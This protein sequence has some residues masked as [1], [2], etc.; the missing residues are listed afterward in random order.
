MSRF[1]KNVV[2]L[3]AGMIATQIIA[4]V[5]SIVFYRKL[6]EDLFGLYTAIFVVFNTFGIF[7]FFDPGNVLIHQLAKVKEDDHLNR[8]A[9]EGLLFGFVS[10]LFHCLAIAIFGRLLTSLWMS[11]VR[12]EN[13]V[14]FS[15]LLPLANF[16][17]QWCLNVVQ[18]LEK[19][20]QASV[21]LMIQ[22]LAR[23]LGAFAGF[24]YVCPDFKV[25][26]L[27][28]ADYLLAMIIGV[29]SVQCIAAIIGLIVAKRYIRLGSLVKR[30]F[31][32]R[33]S[34]KFLSDSMILSVDKKVTD[35]F[36][37]LPRQIIGYAFS[38]NP[39]M[40]A[41]YD[42]LVKIFNMVSATVNP[43]ARALLPHLTR[44]SEKTNWL[45]VK[46]KSWRVI[47]SGFVLGSLMSIGG[48]LGARYLIFPH[49]YQI[50]GV[51]LDEMTRCVIFFLVLFP[52]LGF[53]VINSA[54]ALILDR[55]KL[56][57]KLKF[58]FMAVL[59]PVALFLIPEKGLVGAS[60]Y[61]LLYRG[62]LRGI[63]SL[64]LLKDLNKRT[65]NL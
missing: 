57:F 55:L 14:L 13:A 6:G 63:T 23:P 9:G 7:L 33:P 42:I 47:R 27:S 16:P 45:E 53:G 1:L 59:F 12:L 25:D 35:Q 17:L 48:Y 38:S 5:V 58:V 2:W 50:K 43:L 62:S 10:A 52:V 30:I 4:L 24:L 8:L 32:F 39:G 26:S 51:H 18:G 34:K 44:T 46:E 36:E 20:K 31:K 29:V 65:A 3:Q 49:F 60:F 11:D 54:L 28:G 21:L 22:N 41:H 56:L 64:I 61:A 15:S 40:L 37:L 19:M